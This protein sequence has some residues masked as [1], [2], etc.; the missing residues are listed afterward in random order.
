M[1]FLFINT[2]ETAKYTANSTCGRKVNKMQ[3]LTVCLRT[4]DYYGPVHDGL[5]LTACKI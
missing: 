1:L 4:L 3:T 2:T 5:Y